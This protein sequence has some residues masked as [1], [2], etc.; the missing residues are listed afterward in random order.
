MGVMEKLRGGAA[1]ID[2]GSNPIDTL[3]YNRVLTKGMVIIIERPSTPYSEIQFRTKS[4]G[5]TMLFDI[6]YLSGS[7]V[8]SNIAGRINNA[9]VNYLD[10]GLELTNAAPLTP[11]RMAS[12]SAPYFTTKEYI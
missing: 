7:A 1:L 6:N 10:K 8:A 4:D 3:A 2:S 12:L 9:I 11:L 5:K